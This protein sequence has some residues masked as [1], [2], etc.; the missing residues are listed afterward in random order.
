MSKLTKLK[1]CR[2]CGVLLQNTSPNYPGFQSESTIKSKEDYCLCDSCF[3]TKLR[4]DEQENE[5]DKGY[6]KILEKIREDNQFKN[7]VIKLRKNSEYICN[8][9]ANVFTILL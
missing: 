5:I 4:I 7:I 9:I 8:L 3:E 2:E 6:F 1:R